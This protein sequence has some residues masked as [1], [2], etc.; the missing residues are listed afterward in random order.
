MS[1][2]ENVVLTHKHVLIC[3]E[4]R[5]Q[6][7]N[8]SYRH[9]LEYI[10]SHFCG[11]VHTNL[12]NVAY[13]SDS[14]I[15]LCGDIGDNYDKIPTGH[16]VCVI[17]ELSQNYMEFREFQL[18]STSR[19]DNE[20][21]HVV[22]I[23]EVPINIHNVGVY[24]RKLFPDDVNYFDQ[25]KSSHDFQTLTESNKSSRA[26]RT[27]IY[28]TDVKR[29]GSE[30]SFNLLRC[31]TNLSGPTDNFR[32]VDH[33]ILNKVNNVVGSMFEIPVRLNHVLAQIYQNSVQNVD[34]RKV[35]KKAM[36][37]AH[38]DKTKDMP[39]HALIAFATFYDNT[40]LKSS[41]NKRAPGDMFDVRYKDASVLTRLHFRL[42]KVVCNSGNEQI[43]PSLVKEF[44]VTLYP[45]SVFVIPLSTNR[46]YTHEI[47]PSV[48]SVDKIPTRL[49]Y[50]IRCSNTKAVFKDGATYID[51]DENL[52]KL[53]DITSDDMKT[54]KELYLAENATAEV[55]DYSD[56]YFSMNG[57]DYRMPIV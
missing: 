38:S 25:I 43:N 30:I 52:V 10:K 19:L 7:L 29:L 22:N 32:D 26:F 24:F 33:Q 41:S 53:E 50:V 31:S 4:D 42:K 44:S 27:G 34:Q 55:V 37:G 11:T 8:A 14:T 36:I 12:E 5:F 39:R 16:S 45:N 20:N 56:I 15:Y 9:E 28:L 51:K 3:L 1:D 49:G 17:R 40:S 6:H 2:K 46:L 13:S 54:I 57:G 35:E 47:K 23:G 48:L 18:S 21:Y